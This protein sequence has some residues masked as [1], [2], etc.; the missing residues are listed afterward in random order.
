MYYPK[1]EFYPGY[2]EASM[3]VKFPLTASLFF[4]LFF[5]TNDLY[6]QKDKTQSVRT[7]IFTPEEE[8]A[9][10]K[11]LPG[12][13]VELVA[14]ERDSV[15]NPVDLT[16]DD[17][18][19]LWTQTARMYPLDPISD[20]KWND[21]LKLMDDPVAQKNHPAFKRILDLYQGKTKGTDKI[22]V[23]SGLYDKQKVKATV[24]ADGLTIPMSILPY[25]N[26]AY[27][28]QGSE[29]FFL[30][31]KN[32]DGKADDRIP[33]FTGFG[34]TDT[35]TMA[36]VLV[37]GPGDWINFSQGA[38]NKGEVSALKSNAKLKIDYS[39]I[40]RFSLDAK[41]IELVSNG[42][43]NI[44]GFQ[45]RGNG[46]WYGSEAN[47]LGYSVTPIEPGSGFPGIGNEHLRSYQPFVP[48]LHQFR[49]GGTGIS[50]TAFSDD[51]S[52]SFP[53]EYKNVAFLA[54]PI[55]STINAVQIIRNADGSI[56]SKHLPDLLT[57]EDDWFRPV[58]MEFGPD[59]CL[60]I[61]DW[62]NKIVS[63]NELPTTHPDRDKT[64]GR[65]WR[66][67]HVSQQPRAIPDLYTVPADILPSH[68]KSPSLWEKRAVWHQI[69]DRPASETA[70]LAPQLVAIAGDAEQDET[71]RIHA[72]WSLEG[73][74]YVDHQLIE[75]LLKSASPDLK[76][77]AI[78]SLVSFSLTPAER[79]NALKTLIDDPNPQ[80]RSQVIR[81][82]S[83]AGEADQAVIELLVK[84][85][86]PELPGDVLGGPYERKFERYLARQ[87]LE[88]YASQLQDY[89]SRQV[90]PNVPVVNILWASQALPVAQREAAFIRFWPQ[91]NMD[92]LDESTF[93]SVSGMLGNREIYNLMKPVLQNPASAGTYVRF[94]LQNQAQ[95]QSPELSALMV[96]PVTT[97]LKGKNPSDIDL[98]LDAAGRFKLGLS[99]LIAPLITDEMTDNTL[100]LALKALET[101]AK[102]NEPLFSKIVTN[103]K[104]SFNGRVAAL[105]TLAKMNAVLAQNLLSK[106]APALNASEKAEMTNVLS[107]SKQ[108]ADLL[109]R[110][111][112][113]KL[114]G[115]DAFDL[116]AAERIVN[117]DRRD[118]RREHLLAIVRKR[119]EEKKVAFKGK[120][121]KYMAIADKNQGNAA[122]GKVLF[123]TCLLCHQV[124]ST[125]QAIAPALDGSASRE[126]EALLTAILDPDAAVESGYAVY[127]ITKKDGSSVEGY[128]V[129]KD[130]RGSTI[131]FMGGSKVF[132][133]VS[134]IKNEGFL[135][136]RSFML[137][138]LTDNYSDTQ[139]ADLLTYIKTLK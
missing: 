138:G 125:G 118:A 16:F 113:K 79:A 69:S 11:V 88:Q 68:L 43:N 133:P 70:S 5:F 3:K 30:E 4:L 71:T 123:Q 29:L 33:L 78:R 49:V 98:A 23:L 119:E 106:W 97:L 47:D 21:L 53:D 44:W 15:V 114:I 34:F 37:R 96:A 120:L 130:S 82:L 12:F 45:L 132:I 36:H 20:I 85:C 1:I 76:R 95:V 108:G 111:R 100:K 6:G 42:L 38:L 7:R 56:S 117:A 128:L 121:V 74:K 116:S 124:G 112:E 92:Q 109:M 59:G 2:F 55:T 35:H 136:G 137:K 129:N 77:E 122:N 24:W 41:R 99:T 26:G 63:H 27:V 91:S 40:V 104:I 67:R 14:S 65:I 94:A 25:K 131:A 51:L 22:L 126:N 103:K 58:N 10:F 19:R 8:L 28:A 52:G 54:N 32:H 61:A 72:L 102:A 115:T 13:V 9:G 60:Y 83:E 73:I 64:H 107:G 39:K 57:S 50:G 135:G 75:T 93:V 110:M 66:I 127:R 62:Y 101:E 86:K 134:L 17:A 105:N 18:G 87:A 84:A 80:I 89:I 139:V 46:Q 48:P 81:T 90:A 31:D